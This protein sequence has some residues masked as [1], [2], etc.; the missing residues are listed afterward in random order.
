MGRV[1]SFQ[2]YSLEALWV[3]P[4]VFPLHLHP[5]GPVIPSLD[6]CNSLSSFLSNLLSTQVLLKAPHRIPVAQVI[7]STSMSRALTVYL[8]VFYV[9]IT[10]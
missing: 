2:M 10:E 9:Q 6:Y 8:T 1:A 3:P 5:R 4:D 7:Y